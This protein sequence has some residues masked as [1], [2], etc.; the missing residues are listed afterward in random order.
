MVRYLPIYTSTITNYNH[1]FCECVIISEYIMC[2]IK[3]H[4]SKSEV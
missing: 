4:G 1:Y 2:S 3:Y